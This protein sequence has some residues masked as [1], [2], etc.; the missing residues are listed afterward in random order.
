MKRINLI[1]FLSLFFISIL[2]SAQEKEPVGTIKGKVLD[3][4]GLFPLL[5]VN[6]SVKDKN[7]GVAADADGKYE[8]KKL[9][10]GSYTLIFSYIGY[11]RITKTDIIVRPDRITF[12]DV[13]MKQSSIEMNDVVVNAGYFSDINLRP[14]SVVSFSSEEIR[15]APGAAGDVSR[16]IFGL[17]SLAKLN[18]QKNSLIV[19]GGSPMENAFFVDNVEIPNINHYG[20]QGSSE[21]PIG[22]INVDFLKDVNFYSGG[23]AVNYGDKLS[24]IMNMTFREGNR[25]Q[26]DMQLDLSFQ[27]MGGA[28]EGPICNKGSYLVSARRSYLD[29]IFKATEMKAPIPTYYD[30]Q[31]KVVYDLSDKLKISFLDIG[32]IDKSEQSYEEGVE[33][34][35]NYYGYYNGNKNTA[36]INL[37]YLWGTSGYSNF[38]VSHTINDISNSVSEVRNQNKIYDNESTEQEISFRNLNHYRISESAQFEFGGDAKYSTNDYQHHYHKYTDRFGYETPELIVNNNFNGVKLGVFA[39]LDWK[40]S[41]DFSINPGIRFDYFDFNENTHISPR[42]NL[43]YNFSDATQLYTSGGIFY[44]TLPFILLSQNESY[45]NLKDPLSYHAIMGVSHLITEDTRLTLEVYDKEY[46]DSPIN[47]NQPESFVMDQA[48]ENPVFM[49]NDKLESTGKAYSRGVELIIQKKLAKDFYGMMSASYSRTRYLDGT[50]TWRNRVYDNQF[51]FA[52]E[53]GYKPNESWEFSARWIY[54]GGTPYTP[55]DIPA[56][57]AAYRGIVDRTKIYSER[58]PDYHSL[59]IRVDKRFNFYSSNIVLYISVWNLYGRENIWAYSWD[60]IKNKTK[61]EKSWSTLPV[62]GIEYEL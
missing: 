13:E 23:F 7:I 19:R 8:L 5:G 36:G 50:N 41:K 34:E 62:F 46:R 15:R 44:Q 29:M 35:D 43:T 47:P 54:A 10:I 42:L 3:S 20:T 48:V 1:S 45:K 56:S 2:I 59:N 6:I 17:P 30:F 57:E 18:D 26:F 28:V 24:S 49:S 39:S 25:D 22:L 14:A 12:V 33:F 31:T 40:P 9:P 53:G 21:G 4:E 11:E 61:A 58:L 37:Q 52:F 38:S 60:Q 55:F 27:G 32:A 51:T 16:I